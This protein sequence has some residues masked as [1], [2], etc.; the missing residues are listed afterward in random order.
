MAGNSGVNSGRA[1]E[2][3]GTENPLSDEPIPTLSAMSKKTQILLAVILFVI[4]LI[5]VLGMIPFKYDCEYICSVTGSRKGSI[6]YLRIFK[7][8]HY[9]RTKLEE[10]ANVHAYEFEYN[11]IQIRGTATGLFGKS[12]SH[13]RSPEIHSLPI[14][15]LDTYVSNSSDSDIKELLDIMQEGKASE[16]RE[17]LDRIVDS[18][19]STKD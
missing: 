11:W 4:V 1:R 3:E 13:A 8:H 10:W 16:Q 2:H 19:I 6:S 18:V 17:F 7:R 5:V 12:F 15:V 14:E 9:V